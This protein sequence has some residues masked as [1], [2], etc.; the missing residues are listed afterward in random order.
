MQIKNLM[1]QRERD[2]NTNNKK[3]N[4]QHT[5]SS[6]K[7]IN[8]KKINKNIQDL[9]NTIHRMYLFLNFYLFIYFQREWKEGRKTGRETSM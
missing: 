7:P 1:M 3:I 8:C 2:G 5:T 6:T 4:T 9:N